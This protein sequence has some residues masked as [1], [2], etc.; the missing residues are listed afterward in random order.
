[1][2]NINIGK[3]GEINISKEEVSERVLM[4]REY[5]ENDERAALRGRSEQEVDIAD[6]DDLT[7]AER[8]YSNSV[9]IIMDGHLENKPRIL[10]VNGPGENS[11]TSGEWILTQKGEIWILRIPLGASAREQEEANEKFFMSGWETAIRESQLRYVAGQIEEFWNEQ[12]NPVPPKPEESV[13]LFDMEEDSGEI[14]LDQESPAPETPHSFSPAEG[15][16]QPEEEAIGENQTWDPTNSGTWT[17]SSEELQSRMDETYKRGLRDGETV[18]RKTTSSTLE[19][20]AKESI[21]SVL[22]NEN[23]NKYYTQESVDLL[24]AVLPVFAERLGFEVEK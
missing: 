4:T 15:S 11:D 17:M 19:V 3:D 8:D 1:M 7:E 9:D 22:N 18:S 6:H 21:A 20:I 14:V 5:A 24:G 10:R 13:K 12:G 23:Y 2:I 16:G